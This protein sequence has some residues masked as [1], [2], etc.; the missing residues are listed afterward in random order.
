MRCWFFKAGLD[1][2]LNLIQ[3]F[4]K[5]ALRRCEAGKFIFHTR[6]AQRKPGLPIKFWLASNDVQ[7]F[8]PGELGRFYSTSPLK[9]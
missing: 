5:Q 6:A 8:K 2:S 4:G 7:S 1:G 9:K 3:I